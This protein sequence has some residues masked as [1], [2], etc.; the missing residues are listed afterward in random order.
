MS[1]AGRKLGKYLVIR[2]FNMIY[3][4]WKCLI[5]LWFFSP[6]SCTITIPDKI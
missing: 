4:M 5:V 1:S 6:F 2:E 3:R